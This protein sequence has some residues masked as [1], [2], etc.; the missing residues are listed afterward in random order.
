[1][2]RKNWSNQPVNFIETIDS[3]FRVRPKYKF[4]FLTNQFKRLEREKLPVGGGSVGTVVGSTTPQD[5]SARDKS[6]RAMS[7]VYDEPLIPSILSYEER[8]RDI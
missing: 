2:N 3:L 6:S 5:P 8:N 7:P 4:T 1:M